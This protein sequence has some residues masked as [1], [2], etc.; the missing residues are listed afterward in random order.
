MQRR[1]LSPYSEQ[2][3]YHER[4]QAS[5]TPKL[6]I[7]PFLHSKK[8]KNQVLGALVSKNAPFQI[9]LNQEMQHVS[10]RKI[11]VGSTGQ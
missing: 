8:G 5:Q 2:F 4:K 3:G 6:A 10:N 9:V 11:L 1:I 7:I